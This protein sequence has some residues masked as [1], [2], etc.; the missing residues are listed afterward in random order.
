ME[1]AF[2]QFGTEG[3]AATSI[4]KLC[5]AAGV[6]TRNF[7]QEFAG[8]EALLMAL[9]E[10]ITQRAFTAAAEVLLEAADEPLEQR[11]RRAL[12]T[13]IGSTSTDPRSTRI[14][15][16]ELLGVSPAVEQHRLAWRA[17]LCAFIEA[18]AQ[19][20]IE[21]GEARDRDF[22]HVAIAFIGAVNEMVY[23]WETHGRKVPLSVICDELTR[24]AVAA[25]TA[26]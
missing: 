2:E 19:R 22:H 15:Y 9:H 11:L 14:A 17:R 7:Y 23:D 6:S 21:R 1:V 3:Y 24:L 18:E 4:E 20:A 8:R 16:V 13:Y 25:L 26:P 12:H 10:R 5:S